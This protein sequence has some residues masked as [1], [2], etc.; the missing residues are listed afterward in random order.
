M[1]IFLLGVVGGL[2]VGGVVGWYARNRSLQQSV[3]SFYDDEERED[4]LRSA[5]VAVAKRTERR[6]DRIMQAAN[7]TGQITNDGVEDLFCISD[8]TAS[9]NLRTLSKAGKLKRQ[10]TGRGTFYTVVG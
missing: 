3:L 6:L 4:V 7:Q 2:V 5:H 8:R 9:T 1:G 10:G